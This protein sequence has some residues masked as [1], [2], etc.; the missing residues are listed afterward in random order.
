[1][2]IHT[3][4]KLGRNKKSNLNACAKLC[5]GSVKITYNEEAIIVYFFYPNP[6]VTFKEKALINTVENQISHSN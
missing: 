1:M 3:V 4:C 2:C 6:Q 5:E